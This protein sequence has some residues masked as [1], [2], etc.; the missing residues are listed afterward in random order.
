[1]KRILLALAIVLG[2]LLVPAAASAAPADQG[3]SYSWWVDNSAPV[4]TTYTP[5]NYSYSWSTSFPTYPTYNY[6]YY[7]Y[8]TPVYQPTYTSWYTWFRY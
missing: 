4:Y 6:R 5:Y 8:Q 7:T 2:A 3:Y 1:M